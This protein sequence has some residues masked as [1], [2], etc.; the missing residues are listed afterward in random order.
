MDFY[1]P[2]QFTN[3][4]R[5]CN[6]NSRVFFQ[7]TI[8]FTLPHLQALISELQSHS[9]VIE[10]LYSLESHQHSTGHFDCTIKCHLSIE[11]CQFW[12]Q[13]ASHY[14]TGGECGK[15][16]TTDVKIKFYIWLRSYLSVSRRPQFGRPKFLKLAYRHTDAVIVFGL[17]QW[18]LVRKK[19]AR[20]SVVFRCWIATN[21]RL[22]RP[23]FPHSVTSISKNRK[24]IE[25]CEIL[26]VCTLDCPPPHTHT[27]PYRLPAY[28]YSAALFNHLLSIA[29]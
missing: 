14:P 25:L 3:S 10:H 28:P 18:R 1:K 21:R 13:Q 16:R 26:K 6:Q 5:S 4:E 24:G 11:L 15:H 23:F 8:R 27:Y 29:N 9:D 20:V 7:G 17:K 2:C 12:R 22:N 19:P